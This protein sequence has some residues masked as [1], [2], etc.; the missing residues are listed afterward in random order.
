MASKIGTILS[1]FFIFV[2]FMFGVDFLMIQLN[3]TSLDA[4]SSSVSYKI[5]KSGE[6]SNELKQFVLD[7]AQAR[8]EPVGAD[9]NYEEGS[10]I[11]YYLIK[12]YKMI[13]LDAKPIEIKVKRFTVVN[14]YG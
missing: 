1:M 8:I 2:A 9:H 13:S 12:D 3:Y 6:I 5:S 4:L 14:I 10:V 11:G 7:S